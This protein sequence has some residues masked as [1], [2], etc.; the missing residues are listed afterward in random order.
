[1]G[2]NCIMEKTYSL[3]EVIEEAGKEYT[4][5]K[6]SNG[7]PIFVGDSIFAF[8]NWLVRVEKHEGKYGYF[9]G[10]KFFEL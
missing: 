1:M 3:A 8:A 2:R 9:Y 7:K 5:Q 6:T 4:G 10:G